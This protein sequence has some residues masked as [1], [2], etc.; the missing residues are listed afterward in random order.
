MQLLGG[1]CRVLHLPRRASGALCGLLTAATAARQQRVHLLKRTP[2]IQVWDIVAAV[3]AVAI[4]LR[5][6]L[7]VTTAAA[8]LVITDD[9]REHVRHHLLHIVC[10]RQRYTKSTRLQRHLEHAATNLLQ[11][12]RRGNSAAQGGGKPFTREREISVV[13]MAHGPV[14]FAARAQMA[15]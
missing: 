2:H 3:A 12:Q 7:R 4:S 10:A 14:A 15:G 11:P 1:A 9:A 6:C 8:T 5:R 13:A